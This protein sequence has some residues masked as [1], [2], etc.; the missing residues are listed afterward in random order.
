M[1]GIHNPCDYMGFRQ[2]KSKTTGNTMNRTAE[3]Y[4]NSG[5]AKLQLRDFSSALDDL[6]EAIRLNPNYTF[7]YVQRSATYKLLGDFQKALRDID[8]AIGLNPQERLL[9]LKI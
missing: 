6:N 3:F 8:K 9:Q 2:S 1:R 4:C 7:A 5:I